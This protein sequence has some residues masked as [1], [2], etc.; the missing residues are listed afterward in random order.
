MS[1]KVEIS[2]LAEALVD[3]TFAY[4]VTVGDTGAHIVAVRPILRDA[5]FEISPVGNSAR[6]NVTSHD[7]VTLVWPPRTDDGYTLIVDGIGRLDADG[8]QVRPSHAVLHRPA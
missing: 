5:M 8:L 3:Y 2:L 4:L 6:R 7:T 1:I